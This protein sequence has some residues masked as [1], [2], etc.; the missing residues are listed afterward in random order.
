MED[1]FWVAGWILVRKTWLMDLNRV[2]ASDKIEIV[3]L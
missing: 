2:I 1:E 3:K